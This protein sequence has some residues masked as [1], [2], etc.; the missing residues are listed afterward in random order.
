MSINLFIPSVSKD[1][2]CTLTNKQGSFPCQAEFKSTAAF[3][4][5]NKRLVCISHSNKSKPVSH[6]C[7]KYFA[8]KAK[9]PLAF[10][11]Q[12]EGLIANNDNS[13]NLVTYSDSATV[14]KTDETPAN[15]VPTEPIELT[16]EEIRLKFIHEDS[17]KLRPKKLIISDLK[18][19]F[20]VRSALAGHNILLTGDSGSGKTLAAKSL[21]M[22]LDRPDFYFNLGSTQDPRATLVGNTGYDAATGTYFA[23]SAFV[24]AIKTPNAIILLD[25]IS[26]AHPDAWNILMTVLDMG[27]RYLRL[28]EAEGSP[29]VEVAEGVAFVATA[30]IGSEY[31]ATRV[32]DRALLDRFTIIEIDL[33]TEAEEFRLLKMLYPRVDRDDLKALSE[34]ATHTRDLKL[35]ADGKLSTAVSTRVS[36]TAAGLIAD[37]FDLAEAAEIT[38][39]P[40]FSAEGGLE[41]ERTYIKQLVQKWIKPKTRKPLYRT[42]SDMGAGAGTPASK[43][44]VPSTNDT[45]D[46]QF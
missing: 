4:V 36:V 31:T 37:G 19:K 11:E 28:D 15:P 3:G 25:E 12:I 27:Q 2:S 41:S 46:I 44:P 9:W 39:F 16:P 45:F 10:A 6:Y 23:E 43:A 7:V 22:A 21:V 33:L 8:A 1:G 40:F 34:I 5:R 29:I 26:R 18:W 17:L 14:D 42:W 20:L 13:F 30:N 35:Q 38:I 24:K 32:I